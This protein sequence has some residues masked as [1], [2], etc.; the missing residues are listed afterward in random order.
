MDLIIIVILM[1]IV[2]LIF[3]RVDN[4]VYFITIVDIFFRMIAFINSY[5]PIK[6]INN[7]LGQIP[8]SIP[9]IINHY[10]GGIISDILMW[11]LVI[12]YGM[13]ESYA[14]RSLL[15]RNK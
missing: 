7:F 8:E 3:K 13:F 11:G 1:F 10:T 9:A 6:E 2:V 4:L 5:I 14:I 15:K 12:C